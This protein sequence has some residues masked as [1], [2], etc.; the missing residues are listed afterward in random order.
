MILQGIVKRIRFH[1]KRDNGVGYLIISTRNQD[2]G[3]VNDLFLWNDSYLFHQLSLETAEID[4]NIWDLISVKLI[5]KK[6]CFRVQKSSSGHFSITD[7]SQERVFLDEEQL[8]VT[9][10]SICENEDMATV[11][12]SS[13]NVSLPSTSRSVNENSDEVVFID[14]LRIKQLELDMINKEI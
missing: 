4:E 8:N 10:S 12:E 9:N 14:N 2:D 6:I 7:I 13:L 11:D 3:T 5:N 1:K